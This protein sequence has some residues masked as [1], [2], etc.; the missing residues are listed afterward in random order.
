LVDSSLVVHK[1]TISYW[2]HTVAHNDI[3]AVS[4]IC[5]LFRL[6]VNATLL[7]AL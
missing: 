1:C 3:A 5:L 4:F 7:Q 2:R 6:S